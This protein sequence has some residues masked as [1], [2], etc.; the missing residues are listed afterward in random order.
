MTFVYYPY[1][2]Q[3]S[4]NCLLISGIF[5]CWSF[6][7]FCIG[8]HIICEQR[9]FYLFLPRLYTF[10]FLFLPYWISDN[11][12]YVEKEWWEVTSLTCTWSEWESLEFLTLS[13]LLV[14][15]FCKY[16]LFFKLKKSPSIPSLL[17]F[18]FFLIMNGSW[19]LSN[20]FSASID[21]IMWFFLFSL[22]IW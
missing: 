5:L 9:Q 17:S 7:I 2:L 11:F 19:I 4:C 18:F 12:Q 8:D 1:V 13:M 14:L 3:T 21:M 22:L 20:A 10:Y 16:S 15:G 6:H